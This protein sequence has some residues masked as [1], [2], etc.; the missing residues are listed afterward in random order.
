MPDHLHL[1]IIPEDK[2]LSEEMKSLK[3]FSAREINSLFYGK[4]PIRQRGFYYYLLGSE[5]EVI[6]RIR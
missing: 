4:G 3:G 5:E 6:S 1:I 2:N